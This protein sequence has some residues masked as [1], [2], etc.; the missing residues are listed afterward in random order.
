MANLETFPKPEKFIGTP[1]C[2]RN[3]KGSRRTCTSKGDFAYELFR[4]GKQNYPQP[5]VASTLEESIVK[6][7]E[8][9]RKMNIT[10]IPYMSNPVFLFDTEQLG[11]TNLDRNL[12]FRKDVTGFLGLEQV[13]GEIPHT[14]PGSQVEYSKAEQKTRDKRKI[15]ICDDKHVELR[16]VLLKLARETSQWIRLS[17]F[18]DVPT[19][20]VSQRERFEDSLRSWMD[21]PCLAKAMSS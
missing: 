18:L 15:D 7:Y 2:S 19:V 12:Q 3:V 8:P 20:F 4:L 21:D 13:L 11:D 9:Q 5:R 1:L 17:G 10:A 16:G 6:K 14:T